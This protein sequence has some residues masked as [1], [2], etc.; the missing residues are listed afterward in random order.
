MLQVYVLQ[1]FYLFFRRMLKVL[2]GC[3]ICLTHILQVY[4]LD[5]EY[6]CNDFSCVFQVF[7]QVFQTHVSSV[8]PVYRRMLQMFHL[9]VS[10]VNRLLHMLQ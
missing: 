2:F 7:L 1:M 5:V 4:Y 9:D 3:S 8:L 6:F 10:K